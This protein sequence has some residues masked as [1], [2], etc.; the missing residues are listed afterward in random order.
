M[1]VSKRTRLIFVFFLL[2]A[3]GQLWAQRKITIKLAS[4]VPENTD[5]GRALSQ[6]AGEWARITN[7]EVEVIVYHNGTAG[8]E[9]EVLRKLNINQIQ[10]AVFTSVGLRTVMPELMTVSYPLL[11]RDDAELNE[12]LLK[13]KPEL[14]AKIAENGLIT[15]AWAK[16]GWVKIF[17]RN[18]VF[19]PNDLRRQK[20]GADEHDQQML[21]AFRT[22]GFQMVPVK[23]NIEHIQASLGSGSL[24]AL[25]W[26]PVDFAA[27]QYF[28]TLKNMSSVNLSP[29][30]G[31][32]LM[33]QTA[34]RRIPEKYRPELLA[35]AKRIEAITE[36]S[37]NKLEA[38]AVSV[39]VRYG[40]KVS[41]PNPAQIREWYSEVA[42][43]ENN[44]VG[45]IFDRALYNRIK[46]IVEEYRKGN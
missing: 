44:L 35:Y 13:I 16:A 17:S 33:S 6:M 28:G 10:A 24:D 27:N 37:I 12:V 34:W 26:S 14:D 9:A 19:V 43:Y 42:R 2:I 30:M 45:D 23:M 20:L 3:A 8:S 4:F 32:L 40:L 21:D 31:G 38:D 46:K 25:I 41:E 29:F 39:M 7:G 1:P 36:G 5:W 22:M 11:I 18:P 15:L